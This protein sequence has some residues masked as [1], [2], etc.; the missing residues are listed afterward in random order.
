MGD[1]LSG[2]FTV[3]FVIGIG[4]LLAQFRVL[5]AHGQRALSQVSFWVGLPALLFGSLRQADLERIFSLNVIVSL[6]AIFITLAVYLV[7]VS[8][9]WHRDA[10]HKVIG[11]FASCYVNANNMGLPIAAYVL[12]DTS[13]VAPIL[14]IQVVFLQP[15]GLSILDALNARKHGHSTSMMRNVTLPLRNP[16]TIGVIAG[17]VANLTG[18]RLPELMTATLDLVGGIAVPAMLIA[19]GIALRTGPLPGHG[20]L[21]ETVAISVLKVL[22]QPLL[23]FVLARFAFNLDPVTTLAVTVMAGLPT[24]QNVFIFAMRG[25]E[26]VHLARDAIFITSFASIPAVTA[27]AALAQA[28]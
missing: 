1:L 6:L 18:L 25:E 12:H 11:G 17:L 22:V 23:A 19:F 9:I 4:W 16:M 15:V 20:N 3:W 24:A 13:W 7:L 28:F 5:D 21:G 14:L 2:F 8:T 10:G 26:S 27:M